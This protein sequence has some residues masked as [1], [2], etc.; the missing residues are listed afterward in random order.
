MII[1]CTVP[2][3]QC[4]TDGQKDGCMDGKTDGWKKWHIEVGAATK[5]TKYSKNDN[6]IDSQRD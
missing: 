2:E 6:S 1:W 5:K 4:M 3:I